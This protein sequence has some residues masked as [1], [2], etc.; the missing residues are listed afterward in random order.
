ME[1]YIYAY[2]RKDGTPYYIGKGKDRRIHNRLG[3]KK[4]GIYLPPRDRI[5]I[6]E[7]NLTEIGALALERRYIR[8]YGRRDLGTGILY[9]KTDGGDSNFGLKHAEESKRKMRKPRSEKTK[10]RMRKNHAD[11]RGEK[12]PNY[13][14]PGIK[15]FGSDNPMFGKTHSEEARKLMSKA[16]R[17]YWE[18]RK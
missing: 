7:S 15:L 8:W 11:F 1:Y 14:K 6:M 4:H 5:V 13:G 18:K 17:D 9:N 12:N 3:H 10:E 16:S 2:V